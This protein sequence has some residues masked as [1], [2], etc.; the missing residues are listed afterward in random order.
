MTTTTTMLNEV[1]CSTQ[2]PDVTGLEKDVLSVGR[3][4]YLNCE[5][6]WNR[7]FDFSKASIAL[8]EK[9]KNTIKVFKIESRNANLFQVDIVLYMA[10][11]IKTSN[12][13]ISD[14]I[15]EIDLGAQ[16]F[17]IKSVLEA[18]S[19][20]PPPPFGYIISQLNWPWQYSAAVLFF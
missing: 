12:V 16:A 8:D 13:K 11:D 2:I 9:N 15:H 10:G 18:K 5:G 20:K 3:H 19:E 17:K 1:R 4:F 6:T 14:G 7:E